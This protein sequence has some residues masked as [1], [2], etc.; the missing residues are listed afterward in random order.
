MTKPGGFCTDCGAR[1]EDFRG[2]SRC[3]VCDTVSRPCFD[4]SQVTVSVNWHELH[5]LCV[6]AEN[7]QRDHHLG[8]V[9]Y[10]IARRLQ[11]QHPAQ[12]PL[13]LAGEIGELSKAHG[14]VQVSNAHLRRDI[15]EQTGEETGL[16]RLPPLPIEAPND[17]D[18]R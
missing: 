3:P 8:R 17:E 2:V 7:Y 11:S 9:V 14:E 15:A 18:D 6:W 4:D 5:V 1:I 13:T 16:L 12:Y 10:S